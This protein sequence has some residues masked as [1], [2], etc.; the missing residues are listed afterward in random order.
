MRWEKKVNKESFWFLNE[1][2]HRGTKCVAVSWWTVTYLQ[3]GDVF[4]S[5]LV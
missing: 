2:E 3:S 5:A 1:T 4:G